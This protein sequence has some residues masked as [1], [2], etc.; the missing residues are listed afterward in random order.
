MVKRGAEN[1][2]FYDRPPLLWL[3]HIG[4]VNLFTVCPETFKLIETSCLFVEYMYDYI[5]IVE[6]DPCIS[7]I[8][9]SSLRLDP[10]L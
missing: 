10:P 1:D 7:R 4:N 2:V 9:L 5:C 8:G 3:Y 6:N